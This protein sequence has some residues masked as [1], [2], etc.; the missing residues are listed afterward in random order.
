MFFAIFVPNVYDAIVAPYF[1][2]D[3]VHPLYAAHPF[4][5]SAFFRISFN[6]A[7]FSMN[8]APNVA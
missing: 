3:A 8:G 7:Y 1:L 2:P 5:S 4:I 6:V